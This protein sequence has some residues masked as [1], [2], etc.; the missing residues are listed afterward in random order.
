MKINKAILAAVLGLGVAGSTQAADVFMSG[1]TAM[2]ATMYNALVTDG[3][4]FH[5]APTFTGWGGSGSGDS[6]MAFRGTLVG[7]SGTV[8]IF[9][10]W[11][12]S[13]AGVKDVVT[14]SSKPSY[15]IR[16]LTIIQARILTLAHRLAPMRNLWRPT[17]PWTLPRLIPGAPRP[18]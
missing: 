5:P 15:Q 16:M 14:G 2:R 8:T 12:G 1:S 3:V 11:S 17:W 10:S 9:C 6:Y 18:H 13:E 4:V 7:G